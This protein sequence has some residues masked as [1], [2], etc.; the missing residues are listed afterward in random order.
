M[1][2]II[3]K[4]RN[5]VVGLTY[6]ALANLA[7]SASAATV[8]WHVDNGNGSLAANNFA[9]VILVSNWTVVTATATASS[10][11][12]NSNVVTTAQIVYSGGFGPWKMSAT[13]PA[14]DTDTSYN[15]RLINSY[16]NANTG[17]AASFAISGVPYARYSIYVYFSSDTTNRAGTVSDGTTTYTYTTIGANSIAG[18]NATL[19]Q[20]A[21]TSSSPVANYCIFTNEVSTSKT[22]T[23]NPGSGGGVTGVQIVDTTPALF[24]SLATDIS[25]DAPTTSYVGRT[26]TLSAGIAGTAPITNQWAVDK[27]SGFVSI[28][29]ATNSTLILT[30]AQISDSGIYKLFA[31]NSAGSTNTSPLTL[32]FIA[33]PS[34]TNAL[35]FNVQFCGTAF[36][37][38]AGPA[39]TGAAVIGGGSDVWNLISNPTFSTTTAGTARGTNVALLDVNN[40]GT[41]VTMDYV[42]DYIFRTASTPFASVASPYA[43]LMNGFMGSVTTTTVDTNAVTLHNLVP[44]VYDLYVYSSGRSDAQQRVTV[45]TANGI[46][47]NCGPNSG[48]FTLTAGANYLHLTPTVTSNG[49][50]NL[51][52]YGTV[53]AG[54]GTLNGFQLFGPSTN[55]TLFLTSDTSCDSPANDYVGRTVTLSA[56]FGGIPTPALQWM[57]DNGSGY[58]NVPNA[59]NSTLTLA[60]LQTTN[61][62]SYSLFATNTSGSLNSTPFALNVQTLP[63]PLSVDVQFTGSSYAGG[64][65]ATEV[66][67]AVIGGGSDFWNPVSNPLPT[68]ADTTPIFG[69]GQLLSDVNNYGTAIAL[70]YTGNQIFNNGGNTP[71]NGSGSPAANLMQA[72]LVILNT[73]TATVTLHAIPAG[74]YDVYLYSCAA[75]AAQGTVT[76]FAANDSYDIAGPNS[77]TTALTLE[78]N[79]VH[80]TPTV[81]ANGLLNI[82]LVGAASGQGNLNG[83]QL[84]GPGATPLT[85]TAAFTG[86]PTNL[87]AGS[88]VVF[89]NTSIGS[90]TNSQWNFG[91]GTLFTNSSNSSVTHAYAAVGTYTVSLIVS[92]SGGSSTNT[93]V[94]YIVVNP[95]VVPTIGNPVLS[96]GSLILSGTGLAGTQYR[97]LS[98][99]DLTLPL[100]SWTPVWTNVFAP[101]GTYSYTNSSL[102]NTAGFFRLVTP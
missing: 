34:A 96:G 38:T 45:F 20:T 53:D 26:V 22:I 51:S 60:N 64:V 44:G 14:Q 37:S 8:S 30:N 92:G 101:D 75:N 94:G 54:Q 11:K 41:T 42:G 19:T 72:S 28:A 9:G 1:K 100:A 46:T 24:I 88:S 40:Y 89:A 74:V 18:G 73:N 84:S 78:T 4:I 59:T 25:A 2:T 91:D 76:R 36:G 99:T 27:G 102:S 57:V 95:V 69:N 32:T 49:V 58:V 50:L 71:F 7:G 86:T 16:A 39:Q 77:G 48:T 5:V 55:G 90:V 3:N 10:L 61:S 93:Q 13:T 23:C 35:S 70:D 98:T 56:A 97:I 80:L 6:L 81:T 33:A 85:V 15:K 52:Y 12:N 31:T 63:N 62:G 83:I 21:D 68:G 87:I 65:A 29:N 66:G 79:Y 82:S 43:N 47:A 17:T 67:G